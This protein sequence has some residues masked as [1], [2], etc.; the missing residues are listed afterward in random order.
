MVD[1]GNGNLVHSGTFY[2]P[3]DLA[4]P[5]THDVVTESEFESMKHQHQIVLERNKELETKNKELARKL[6]KLESSVGTGTKFIRRMGWK[7]S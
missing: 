2:N 4:L 3:S 7:M 5:N 6:T 1:D